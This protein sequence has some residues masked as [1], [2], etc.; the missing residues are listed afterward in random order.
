MYLLGLI[1]ARGGSVRV[2]RKNLRKIGPWTLTEWAIEYA[3]RATRLDRYVVCS[4]DAEIQLV[5]QRA[6]AEVWVEPM[7]LAHKPIVEVAAW[8]L[9]KADR[10]G[11]RPDVVVVLQPTTP[12]RPLQFVELAVSW[13]K[14]TDADSLVTV[15]DGRPTGEFY[16]SRRETILSGRL[17]GPNCRELSGGEPPINIDT[18][19][20]L[21][22]AERYYLTARGRWWCD[23]DT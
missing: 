19:W 15:K 7:A 20:D 17:L 4:E 21:V 8:A 1:P 12:F 6:G 23:P 16:A 11:T 13:F 3:R 18:E 14:T 10:N 5:A 22:Q 9:A 2:S